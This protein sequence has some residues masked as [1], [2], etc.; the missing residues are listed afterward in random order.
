[1]T[2]KLKT[3]QFSKENL[4]DFG[5]LPRGEIPTALQVDPKFE[6]VKLNNG[7]Q[8]G[9]EHFDGHHTGKSFKLYLIISGFSL[10]YVRK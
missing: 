3:F 4:L 10:Y 7:A 1:M 2:T 5:D 6:H 9:F 8:I